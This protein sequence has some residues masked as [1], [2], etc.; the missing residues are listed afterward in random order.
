MAQP[1][2][3]ASAWRG[4]IDTQNVTLAATSSK[5]CSKFNNRSMRTSMYSIHFWNTGHLLSMNSLLHCEV[6]AYAE[7]YKRQFRRYFIEMVFHPI[8]CKESA[9][10]K[11]LS[12]T[13]NT[14]SN[15][16][17]SNVMQYALAPHI[18]LKMVYRKLLLC[19][20]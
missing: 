14:S 2:Q 19:R 1:P 16:R 18:P 15:K 13:R 7:L 11:A 9:Y 20:M 8:P 12:G 4:I 10:S 5:C 6:I 17:I 3:V